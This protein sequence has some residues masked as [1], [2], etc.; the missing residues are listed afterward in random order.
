[1]VHC[2]GRMHIL[3]RLRQG[4][5]NLRKFPQI[6]AVSMGLAL[7]IM[8]MHS[9]QKFIVACCC[10]RNMGMDISCESAGLRWQTARMFQLKYLKNQTRYEKAATGLI[11]YF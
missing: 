4:F 6:Y 10:C 1:M 2:N 5:D 11:S 8:R 9:F 3:E 7:V